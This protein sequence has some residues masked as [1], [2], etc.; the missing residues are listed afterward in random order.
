MNNNKKLCILKSDDAQ[1]SWSLLL[2]N[3]QIRMIN[4]LKEQGWDF[5]VEVIDEP[6]EV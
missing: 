5:T 2:N 3:D 4:F 6:I 1:V